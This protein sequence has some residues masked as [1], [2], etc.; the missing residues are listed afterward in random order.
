MIGGSGP[1]LFALA[2]AVADRVDLVNANRDGQPALGG[3]LHNGVP[4]LTELR[5]IALRAGDAVGNRP[6]FSA[7][8]LVSLSP[9][10]AEVAARRKQTAAATGATED[11]IADDLLYVIGDQ[12]HLLRALDTLAGLGFDRVHL[13]VVPPDPA[14]TLDLISELLPR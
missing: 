11:E 12:G 3:E 10:K 4:R 13:G 6:A 5:D 14:A 2:G 1:K 7:T 9:D 8:V